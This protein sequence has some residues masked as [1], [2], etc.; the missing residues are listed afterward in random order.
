VIKENGRFVLLCG[1]MK[2]NLANAQEALARCR[3][4]TLRAMEPQLQQLSP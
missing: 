3:S 4:E 2:K 1:T